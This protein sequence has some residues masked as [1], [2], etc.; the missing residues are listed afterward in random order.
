MFVVKWGR[1]MRTQKNTQR[2]KRGTHPIRHTTR[3]EPRMHSGSGSAY[4]SDSDSDD[5]T[6]QLFPYSP[7]LDS[8]GHIV[9]LHQRNTTVQ[10][11]HV[12]THH[13]VVHS[14]DRNV[15]RE[16]LFQFQVL[17]G[18][19]TAA[20]TA[21]TTATTTDKSTAT[22][23]CA[24]DTVYT[25]V[26]S[27]HLTDIL[28]PHA[29]FLQTVFSPLDPTIHFPVCTP[30]EL[31][32]E[33]SPNGCHQLRG[34]NPTS[35]ISSFYCSQ[36]ATSNSHS[37]YKALNSEHLYDTPVNFLSNLTFTVHTEQERLF[38]YPF[39][40]CNS[41]DLHE[42]QKIAFVHATTTIVATTH[43]LP[44][45]LRVGQLVSFPQLTFAQ[46]TNAMSNAEREWYDKLCAL[47]AHSFV[48]VAVDI[49]AKTVTVDASLLG[50]SEAGWPSANVVL[51]TQFDRSVMMNESMQ[52][53]FALRF[54]CVEK[55]LQQSTQELS[56]TQ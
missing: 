43:T 33:M 17:F 16:H 40:V 3:E 28:L 25:D 52:Y 14:R 44:K 39:S 35:N 51:H 22:R 54:K 45:H 49:V 36:V 11:D 8:L 29:A 18:T 2:N 15:F 7:H 34:T 42:I 1:S 10:H 27:L 20:T 38:T 21:T 55:R 32:V 9:P 13:V 41:P 6:P 19:E 56:P 23:R 37:R 4:S 50:L 47:H 53:S 26:Q 12:R 46:T 48:V 30:V 24:V 5:H 31:L